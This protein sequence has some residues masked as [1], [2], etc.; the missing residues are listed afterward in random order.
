MKNSPNQQVSNLPKTV[1]SN[2]QKSNAAIKKSKDQKFPETPQARTESYS[3]V[4]YFDK[5]III[6]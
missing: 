5:E 6:W 3:R 1:A 2:Q 4:I